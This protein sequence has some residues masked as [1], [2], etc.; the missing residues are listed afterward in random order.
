MPRWSTGKRRRGVFPPQGGAL[1]LHRHR[2]GQ[3]EWDGRG[4][5]LL[6]RHSRQLVLFPPRASAG[7]DAECLLARRGE[8]GWMTTRLKQVW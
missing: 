7:A 3:R 5:V 2:L 8:G 6:L 1:S 4:E